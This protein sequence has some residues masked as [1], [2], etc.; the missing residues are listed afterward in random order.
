MKWLGRCPGCSEWGTLVEEQVAS[1]SRGTGRVLTGM[2]PQVPLTEVPGGDEPRVPPG[3]SE[4]DRV[5]GGGLVPG[6]L[7]LLGGEPGIG[8]STLVMQVLGHLSGHVRALLVP[9]AELPGVEQPLAQ[10]RQSQ[11][12]EV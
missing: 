5:L 7:V 2:G 6:S 4:F 12:V 3:V 10:L 8:K 9:G 11:R 1:S